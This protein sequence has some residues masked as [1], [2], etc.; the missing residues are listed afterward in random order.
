MK[1][2]QPMSAIIA[3]LKESKFLKV[4]GPEGE[5][6]VSR[7][8]PYDPKD[9]VTERERERT[10]RSVYAKG[11]GDE[12][13]STQFDIE[14][15][16]TPYGP[17]T[18]IRLRRT[19]DKLFKGSVFVEFQDVE[20]YER[21]LAVDPKPLWKGEHV[22]MI[23]PKQDYID[24]K[25]EDIQEGRIEP[26]NSNY[27]QGFGGGRGRGRGRGRGQ[28][29]DRGGDRGGNRG[30]F[31]DR[32]DRD[33]G[34]RDPN[35]WKKRREEDRANGFKDDRKGGRGRGRGRGGRGGNRDRE[36]RNGRLNDRN[37]ECDEKNG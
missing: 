28:G 23:Q 19:E 4:S 17:T 33:R 16:F 3:A 6:G 36:D 8:V 37:R 30:G 2:F 11:F 25:N 22:L 27:T 21:F 20:T 9:T 5:E 34:D 32:N 1:R 7:V 18:S 13:P 12:E 10:S 31:R 29:G 24:R 35:D 14:A 26:K 15:F